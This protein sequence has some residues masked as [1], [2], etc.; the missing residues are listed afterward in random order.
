[1]ALAS[2]A[3]AC[4]RFCWRRS[5]LGPHAGTSKPYAPRGLKSWLCKR[6]LMLVCYY[7]GS[8]IGAG[9]TALV[10]GC[11]RCKQSCIDDCGATH[12]F[13][14]PSCAA[15]RRR[16]DHLK[17]LCEALQPRWTPIRAASL[18]KLPTAPVS[19]TACSAESSCARHCCDAESRRT[20]TTRN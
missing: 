10:G 1:M 20:T 17:L 4:W 16:G 7:A 18:G 3:A 13:L 15:L 9:R 11:S 19:S 5:L 2:D 8:S 12:H 6:A 14:Q